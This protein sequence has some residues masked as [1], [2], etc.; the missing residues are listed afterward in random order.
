MVLIA[1]YMQFVSYKFQLPM[2]LFNG[3]FIFM[4][5]S[6]NSIEQR[7]LGREIEF[8]AQDNNSKITI[9]NLIII[10]SL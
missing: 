2:I 4:H 8:R 6:A 10:L 1:V 9:K 7:S 5:A 3:F